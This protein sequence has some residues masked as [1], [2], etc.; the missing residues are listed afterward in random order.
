MIFQTL[1]FLNGRFFMRISMVSYNNHLFSEFAWPS[2]ATFFFSMIQFV[3]NYASNVCWT[4]AS[5]LLWFYHWPAIVLQHFC[6]WSSLI[7]H[8]LTLRQ[9]SH[10]ILNGKRCTNM[11]NHFWVG[12]LYIPRFFFNCCVLL[13]FQ[14]YFRKGC[15][16]EAM[17][18]YDNVCL[19]SEGTFSRL[20]LSGSFLDKVAWFLICCWYMFTTHV[21]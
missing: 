19:N 12:L 5:S 15:V 17:E 18:Q 11:H 3:N 8:L 16:L 1:K 13:I 20:M 4:H 14:G 6:N 9:L 21:L 7:K 10:W 2:T